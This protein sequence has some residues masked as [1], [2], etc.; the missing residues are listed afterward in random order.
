MVFFPPRAQAAP[1][2]LPRDREASGTQCLRPLSCRRRAAD[3]A[4]AARVPRPRKPARHVRRSV[5]RGD[6]VG[7][8]KGTMD[9]HDTPA[10]PAGL[11]R[12]NKEA[13]APLRKLKCP[14]R[15]GWGGEGGYSAEAPPAESR[16]RILAPAH[17]LTP[18]PVG[19]YLARRPAA[20]PG[21]RD[22]RAR[23]RL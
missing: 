13:R 4:A 2:R 14:R 21:P 22:L 23:L 20:R 18:A 17:P 19:T 16:R 8:G 3:K 9:R 6:G 5:H 1:A 7:G 12:A 10:P 15:G 11:W